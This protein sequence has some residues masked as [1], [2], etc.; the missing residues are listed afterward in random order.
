MDKLVR[1]RNLSTL[2]MMENDLVQGSRLRKMGVTLMIYR[3]SESG[4]GE[5]VT[6]V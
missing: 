1:E 4:W 2:M 6:G 5:K 3:Y